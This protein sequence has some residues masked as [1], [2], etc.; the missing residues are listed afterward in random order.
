MD[1]I[2]DVD[3]EQCTWDSLGSFLEMGH[4][5]IANIKVMNCMRSK[6]V[7]AQEDHQAETNHLLEEKFEVDH[8][9]KEKIAE[10]GGLLKMV[11]GIE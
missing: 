7:K 2:V 11:Q 4:Q 9:L 10:V 5:L 8:L 6:V 3:Y 1:K